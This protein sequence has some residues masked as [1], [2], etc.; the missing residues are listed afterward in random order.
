ML[1][2]RP[3]INACLQSNNRRFPQ[4]V[5][6]DETRFIYPNEPEAKFYHAQ[7]CDGFEQ[8]DAYIVAQAPFSRETRQGQ[9]MATWSWNCSVMKLEND[10]IFRFLANVLLRASG[11]HRGYGR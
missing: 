1:A 5:C 7:R 9:L 2:D 8:A 10:F 4:I 6:F 11:C 3:T